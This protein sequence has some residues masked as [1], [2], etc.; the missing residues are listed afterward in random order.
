[1]LLDR[2]HE[3]S[4]KVNFE[5]NHSVATVNSLMHTLVLQLDV[6]SVE[7]ESVYFFHFGVSACIHTAA[8][9]DLV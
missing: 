3:E 1:M 2:S 7:K 5:Q 8:N 9:F 6:K 4:Q